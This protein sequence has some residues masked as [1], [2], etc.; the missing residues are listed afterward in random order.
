MRAP[1][2][3]RHKGLCYKK[4]S[5]R[6]TSSAMVKVIA[7][8]QPLRMAVFNLRTSGCST[9]WAAILQQRDA[10]MD[11]L[12][13]GTYRHV[14][15]PGPA[16]AQNATPL[17]PC[18]VFASQVLSYNA[19]ADVFLLKHGWQSAMQRHDAQG[20]H[21]ACG[22]WAPLYCAQ[23]NQSTVQKSVAR[24]VR[25]PDAQCCNDSSSISAPCTKA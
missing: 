1:P 10:T 16:E 14:S 9:D 4:K 11:W 17:P 8:A 12:T 18:K 21:V 19:E 15:S 6:W 2:K 25:F 23:C 7:P 3:G 5:D 20:A 22:L 13:Q 24:T